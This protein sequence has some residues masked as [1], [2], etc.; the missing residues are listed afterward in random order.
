MHRI[1]AI[2]NTENRVI[3]LTYRIGRHFPHSAEIFTDL[4]ARV[5]RENISILLLG[6]PGTQYFLLITYRTNTK[7]DIGKGKTTLLREF[8]R[9]LADEYKQR[10]MIIDTSN[11][12]GGDGDI[13]HKCIGRARRMPVSVKRK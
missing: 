9:L 3:G 12:I 5:A 8:S 7:Y 13:A 2:K 1:S 6:K 11:E 4:I 10:V